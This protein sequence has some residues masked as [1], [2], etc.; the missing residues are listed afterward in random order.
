LARIF[1]GLWRGRRS[2]NRHEHSDR[3]DANQHRQPVAPTPVHKRA[4]HC[5][6]HPFPRKK[7]GTHSREGMRTEC[8]DQ[9][10]REA[11]VS[12]KSNC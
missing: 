5:V 1:T 9:P 8:Q 12:V 11:D 6:F 3:K 2:P 4:I 10:Q 7:I